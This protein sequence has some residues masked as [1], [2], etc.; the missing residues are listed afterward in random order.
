MD[1]V[2]VILCGLLAAAV[3]A[4]GALAILLWNATHDNQG[5]SMMDPPL[6][7]G[8]MKYFYAFLALM[9]MVLLILARNGYAELQPP[10]GESAMLFTFVLCIALSEIYRVEDQIKALR[11]RL[12]KQDKGE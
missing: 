1:Y 3:F 10:D 7:G 11:K 4:A 12:D 5:E 6:K 9:C 8:M 2:I